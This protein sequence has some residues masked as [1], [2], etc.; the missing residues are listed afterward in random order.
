M[1][2]D[3]YKLHD[4]LF[5]LRFFKWVN[6]KQKICH[7]LRSTQI[8]ACQTFGKSTNVG[9]STFLGM[10][11]ETLQRTPKMKQRINGCSTHA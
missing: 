8:A 11:R 2:N 10:C 4:F 9:K 5:Y 7:K 6:K 3:R 1:I